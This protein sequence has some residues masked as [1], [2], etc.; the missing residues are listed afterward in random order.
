MKKALL[1]ATVQSHIGQF[2]RPLAEVLHEAGYEVHVAAQNNLAVKN[3]LS[4]DFIDKVYDVPF[5]RSPKSPKNLKAY[6]ELKKILK[7]EHYDIVSCN[8]PM[9]G[10]VTRLAAIGTRKK[11]TKVFY[12]AHGFHFF[13]GSSKKNWLVFYPIEKVMARL[14][15]TLITITKEDYRLA[16]RKF[17]T[18]VAH[19]H[20]VGVY[21]DRYHP[22][23][24]DVAVMMR[25]KEG[26]AKDDY[27][28]LCVGELNQNKNQTTLIAASEKIIDQIP[29]LKIL[30]AGNGPK[31]EELRAQIKA[32]GLEENI[33]LLGYRT[34]LETITPAVDLVVSCSFREGLP[35]NILEAEL[36]KKPVI[37]SI[38]RGHNELIQEGKSGY[39]VKADDVEAYVERIL[40]VYHNPELASSMGRVGYKIA[41]KYTADA[42]A[43]ELKAIYHL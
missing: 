11:G 25:E 28:I 42:V 24:E 3:G 17:R 23:S 19:I 31:E 43:D 27:V 4:L 9:G 30:L 35:L 10:I 15:D 29:N 16:K 39:K 5:D 40:S 33:I 34:D 8:T 37:A 26:L 2:H 41:M 13:K 18:N 6:R 36:C 38:N 12:T 1:T 14:C 7:E 32:A 20:G 22:V 21:T